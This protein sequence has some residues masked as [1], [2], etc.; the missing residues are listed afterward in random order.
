MRLEIVKT[1]FKGHW[2]TEIRKNPQDIRYFVFFNG[3]YQFFCG[4]L[5]AAIKKIDKHFEE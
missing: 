5:E 1:I 2:K 4:S 3:K